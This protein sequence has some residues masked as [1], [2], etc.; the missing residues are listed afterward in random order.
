[1]H[2]VDPHLLSWFNIGLRLE[3]SRAGAAGDDGSA[4]IRA[5]ANKRRFGLGQSIADPANG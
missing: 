4:I 5:K 3:R 1:L 2:A